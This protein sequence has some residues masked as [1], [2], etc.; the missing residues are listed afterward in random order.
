MS[1]PN[2]NF[3]RTDGA[4]SRP[5]LSQDGISGFVFYTNGSETAT[6]AKLFTELDALN[7][8]NTGS[9]LDYHISE[10]FRFS[11]FPLYLK[12]VKSDPTNFSEVQSLKDFSNGELRQ[13]AILNYRTNYSS[14][15]IT[16]LQTI[17]D[18]CEAEY[19][20]V[21]M[22]YTASL[23]SST[24]G[25]ALG[26]LVTLKTLDCP[27]VSYCIA[28][29]LSGRASALRTSTSK[30]VSA[31][32]TLLGMVSK[33]NVE[34]SIGWV[35]DNNIVGSEHS[36][37][38]FITGDAITS[39]SNTLQNTLH[40]YHY[41]SFRKFVNND[42]VFFNYGWTCAASDFSTIEY[43]RAYD[44]A[45]RNLRTVY[46][47]EVNASIY[48][49]KDGT[50]SASAIQYF[51]KIGED[52]MQGLKDAGNISD[53]SIDIDPTQQPIISGGLDVVAKI[54]PV[55][56]ASEIRIKLGFTL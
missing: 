2:V 28:E 37:V 33:T 17:A 46:L 49:N 41:I 32:G 23:G 47:P 18:N 14:S 11:S 30:F 22:L 27:R 35:R 29:D 31:I 52:V 54:I 3:F 25:T 15:H 56:V 19:A 53:Y 55:G 39:V 20:P 36:T 34:K 8:T 24:S 21:Q 4:I 10:Y 7:Y 48:V 9:V 16:G 1:L 38:G 45:F 40:D 6:T 5:P 43:N 44:K 26:S 51:K 12:I 13:C 42:G 50:I